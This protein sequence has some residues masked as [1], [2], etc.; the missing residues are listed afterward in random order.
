MNINRNK[1]FI[2]NKIIYIM[3]IL[4]FCHYN[5]SFASIVKCSDFLHKDKNFTALDGSID[6]CNKAK[7]LVRSNNN[8][9]MDLSKYIEDSI[10]LVTPV[11]DIDGNLPIYCSASSNQ[12]METN[13]INKIV[14][15]QQL[16]NKFSKGDINE[17]RDA[18]K[19]CGYDW[20]TYA[21]SSNNV[22]NNNKKHWYPDFGIFSNSYEY[23]L[24]KIFDGSYDCSD[25]FI[26]SNGVVTI[27]EDI[28][29]SCLK[30]GTELDKNSKCSDFR[31]KCFPVVTMLINSRF[32]DA[33]HCSGI[34]IASRNQK[35]RFY[36]EMMYGGEE[37]II[38]RNANYIDNVYNN[39]VING[40]QIYSYT[41]GCF[42]PRIE[43]EKGFAGNEQR[44][45]FRGT[46][47]ANYA[48][49]RF[50]YKGNL[51]LDARGKQYNRNSEE[52]E[53]LFE[54]AKTCCER[55][56][57]G[58][59]CLYAPK[60]LVDNQYYYT[61]IDG[62]NYDFTVNGNKTIS[63]QHS[64][65]FCSNVDVANGSGVCSL[66]IKGIDNVYYEIYEGLL[67]K[68]SHYADPS[69][70]SGKLCVR[71]INLFP[72]NFNLSYGT[73]IKDLYCDGDYIN[74]RNPFDQE[75]ESGSYNKWKQE[76]GLDSTKIWKN[77][78]ETENQSY[79]SS[80]QKVKNFCEQ[81][82]HCVEYQDN[83]SIQTF[84]NYRDSTAN[85]FLPEVCFNFD[86]GSSQNFQYPVRLEE[87]KLAKFIGG[88]TKGFLAPM[89][90]CLTETI[91]NMFLNIAGSSSCK[92]TEDTINSEGL[93]GRDSF[94]NPTSIRHE[95]YNAEYSGDKNAYNYIIGEKLS[96]DQNIFLKLQNLVRTL[97][98]TF[99]TMA[100]VI[101][102]AKF[103][104]V[105]E[106]DL[107]GAKSVKAIIMML[108]KIAIVLYFSLT[109]VWQTTFYNWLMETVRFVNQK[110]FEFSFLD[111]DDYKNDFSKIACDVKKE[112]EIITKGKAKQCHYV[113]TKETL[114]NC[115]TYLTP[116]GYIFDIKNNYSSLVIKLFGASSGM[117]NTA[118]NNNQGTGIGTGEVG[119]G[120]YTYGVWNFKS[121]AN[122]PQRLYV[123]IGGMASNNN[124][125]QEIKNAYGNYFSCGGYNGGGNGGYGYQDLT[126]QGGGGA[127]DVRTIQNSETNVQRSL[128]SRIMVAG[129]GGGASVDNIYSGGAGGGGNNLGGDGGNV[130]NDSRQC[131][132]N[133][134]TL[135][136]GG[137]GGSCDSRIIC[138]T[139]E[140][141]DTCIK[142]NYCNSYDD[143]I[144]NNECIR[145]CTKANNLCSFTRQN[146]I[147]V[148]NLCVINNGTFGQGGDG[149]DGYKGGSGGG[150]GYYG[151]GASSMSNT[152]TL[153]AATL[154]GGGGGGSG[155]VDTSLISQFGGSNGV[156]VGNGVAI[157][158]PITEDADDQSATVEVLEESDGLFDINILPQDVLTANV[159]DEICV[160]DDINENT[161]DYYT[162]TKKCYI[163]EET[164]AAG[165]YDVVTKNIT[166]NKEQE[167]IKDT[168]I[169]PDKISSYEE[170]KISNFI[171]DDDDEKIT[172]T[173]YYN[174]CQYVIEYDENGDPLISYSDRY[175]GCYF[176]NNEYPEGKEYLM[177]FDTLD[178]K[179]LKYYGMSA[180]QGTLV[181]FL[182][183]CLL[184][185][186]FG[187][188]ILSIMS[189][190]L[191]LVF[192][193]AFKVFYIYIT[194]IIMITLLIFISPI[195][196]PF[197]LIAKYKGIFDNWLSNL[198][199]ACF[200]MLFLMGFIGFALL[201]IDDV[202]L[203][204]GRYYNHDPYTGRSPSV[205]CGEDGLSLLC[206]IANNPNQSTDGEQAFGEEIL[207]FLGLGPL[208]YSVKSIFRVGVFAIMSY[209]LGV[210]IVIY[211]MVKILDQ[212][213]T[214]TKRIFSAPDEVGGNMSFKGARSV[215]KNRGRDVANFTRGAHL[216]AVK[217]SKKIG[218]KTYDKLSEWH[219]E[220]FGEVAKRGWDNVAKNFKKETWQE[221][222]E[223]IK[224]AVV[225]KA[226]NIKDGAVKAYH[227]VK[228]APG[229]A[230]NGVKRGANAAWTG[231]KSVPDN[232]ASSIRKNFKK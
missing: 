122:R 45:Y 189:F 212:I 30:N 59:V 105:G 138:Q 220:G 17:L 203:G 72:Y 184:S 202:T 95:K 2:L 15:G 120:G 124:C 91:K 187:I 3:V 231:I 50:E 115:S 126:G 21:I 103:L 112:K 73:E 146:N 121:A 36:R 218:R 117:N 219:K 67:G 137:Q 66:N 154:M 131:F 71:T 229:K 135:T 168:S 148:L 5:I 101:A 4:W 152:S 29:N 75:L 183:S 37:F 11:T 130:Y 160:I 113:K 83:Q 226:D 62:V 170:Y 7:A 111:Y 156:H 141:I 28:V 190:M 77:A 171:K 133:G 213:P 209:L 78:L 53:A 68:D 108:I 92:S 40:E 211:I 61:K 132:G 164:V 93:C 10:S 155:Y 6:S 215:V 60:K 96:E 99:V 8:G 150:G 16:K 175:D 102:S 167:V 110:M 224:N 81:N 42:D 104:L 55:R 1:I 39:V 9:L 58:G 14:A 125:S 52:C 69:T 123:Y 18:V 84:K 107:F 13:T 27:K 19:I 166:Y 145:L 70:G 32:C 47:A 88:G 216:I 186:S 149:Q 221:R 225:Q 222:G 82:M 143:C 118:G 205:T 217:T 177:V 12:P 197:L 173:T 51:C 200:Q 181:V 26:M 227:T 140:I 89:A 192:V 158:C 34:N 76:Y 57:S 185:A 114:N 169:L 142:N 188:F 86:N 159:G 109:D 176:G 41:D 54:I 139:Q 63:R 147:N 214:F 94:D 191:F 127:T 119:K 201:T 163:C 230:W 129:G 128:S 44:Y 161:N 56:S 20:N 48:C 85:K 153:Q 80:Y 136:N 206:F 43:G 182:L 35:N 31:K 64:T 196:F 22:Q 24:L 38:P 90:E 100:I 46:K 232:I 23:K 198:M 193:L 162:I 199:G 174:N 194:N 98:I 195:I 172:E 106:F 25:Y 208:L 116:G 178:C 165:Q 65:T 223:N 180:G 207:N 228:E 49:E 97:I 144:V 87:L 134:G 179:I 74:C 151:G 79:V 157:I 210:L 204:D 33:T